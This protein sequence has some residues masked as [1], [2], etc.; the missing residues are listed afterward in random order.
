MQE[1]G[2]SLVQGFAL[3]SY[4]QNVFPVRNDCWLVRGMLWEVFSALQG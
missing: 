1:R 3:C 4:L 2:P